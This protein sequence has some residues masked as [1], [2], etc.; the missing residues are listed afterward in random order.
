MESGQSNLTLV[1][2]LVV[3]A[4]VLA[5]MAL[6]GVAIDRALE[7]NDPRRPLARKVLLYGGTGL[8]L[9]IMLLLR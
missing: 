8:F 5:L 1:Q 4:A 2:G 9:V 6:A 7:P 3:M